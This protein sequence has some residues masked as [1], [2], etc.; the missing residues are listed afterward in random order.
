MDSYVLVWKV[1]EGYVT[2]RR[3]FATCSVM[4][5]VSSMTCAS[6]AL[7]LCTLTRS[8]NALQ[9]SLCG[10][11][12][13]QRDYH[14]ALMT[15]NNQPL[16]ASQ[17]YYTRFCCIESFLSPRLENFNYLVILV[18]RCHCSKGTSLKL[19]QRLQKCEN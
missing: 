18:N 8:N 17:Q 15:C 16:C 7:N 5:S 13:W 3:Y 1:A 19:S 6:F 14:L 10:S 9:R 4:G 12:H 2:Y 11:T